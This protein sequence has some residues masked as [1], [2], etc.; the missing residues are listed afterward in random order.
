[1]T[2]TRSE[3]RRRAAA[4][5]HGLGSPT[6]NTTNVSDPT[7]SGLHVTHGS[8]AGSLNGGM[9]TERQL[10]G[11]T[12]PQDVQSASPSGADVWIA[13]NLLVCFDQGS[14]LLSSCPCG[15]V[16][17]APDRLFMADAPHSP[18]LQKR[19]AAAEMEMQ[20]SRVK[21]ESEGD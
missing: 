16:V 17:L 8:S 21:S 1:M 13:R 10:L 5:H 3:A 19:I 15:A 2:R 18:P 7:R 12:Q 20:K 11:S 6:D 4:G 14:P 9:S